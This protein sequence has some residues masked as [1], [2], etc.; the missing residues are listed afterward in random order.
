[1]ETI[2]PHALWLVITFAVGYTLITFEHIAKI[3]KATIALLTAVICWSIVFITNKGEINQLGPFCEELANISQVVFF[4]L[5]ALAVVEIISV[6]NGFKILSDCVQLRSKRSLLWLVTLITFFLSSILDNLTTTVVM[7]SLLRKI[8]VDE[9]DRW[10]IG[11][12]VVIAANAGGAWTPIGDVTTTMLWIGG[13]LTTISMVKELF[14]PSL[15]CSAVSCTMLMPLLKGNLPPKAPSV[16]DQKIDPISWLLFFLGLGLLVFVPIFKLLT[17]LPPFM[18]ILLALSILWL[19]TD[20]Y[21]RSEPDSEHLK[22]PHVLSKIDLSGILFFLGILLAVSALHASGLLT[23]LAY[24]LDSAVGNTTLI[25]LFIGLA[26]AVIDNVPLVAASMGMYDV[27]VYP[28]DSSF[29]Q[30]IAYCA[31][32]GGSI[33]I[34]GSAAGIVFMG[35]EGVNFVWYVRRISL[36]ALVGYLAG[37]ASY[38]YLR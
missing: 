20:I 16:V 1:M 34:V 13:Q 27:S 7:L 31:G 24:W 28:T 6:H 22:V 12:A 29:W 33:L 37:A 23:S 8:I 18:G 2:H 11:G 21:H 3:N 5:G 9:N 32:T 35:M 17:G 15:V 14:F 36:A 10:V 4:L 19:V 25:A 30:L 38:I 26:S